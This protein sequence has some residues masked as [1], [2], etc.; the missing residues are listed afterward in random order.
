M[1]GTRVPGGG[2]IIKLDNDNDNDNGDVVKRLVNEA[3]CRGLLQVDEILE[4]NLERTDDTAQRME[5]RKCS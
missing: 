4:R 2:G 5:E 3:M 1:E